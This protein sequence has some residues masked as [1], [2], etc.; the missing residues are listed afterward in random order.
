[1][2]AKDGKHEKKTVQTVILLFLFTG[3]EAA[4]SITCDIND[5]ISRHLMWSKLGTVGL[6]IINQ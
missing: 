5:Y 2:A 3:T 4:S 6:S 1:M